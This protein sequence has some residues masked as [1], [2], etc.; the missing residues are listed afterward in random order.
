MDNSLLCR[1]ANL[2]GKACRRILLI[3]G[4][5]NFKLHLNPEQAIA[6]NEPLPYDNWTPGWTSAYF[7]L[8]FRIKIRRV[9]KEN[10]LCHVWNIGIDE[11]IIYHSNFICSEHIL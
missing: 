2:K 3:S 10:M 5:L 8:L 6:I 7:T 4:I 1:N 11:K 9:Q